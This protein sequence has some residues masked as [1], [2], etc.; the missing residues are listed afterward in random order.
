MNEL[1]DLMLRRPPL[2]LAVAE[3]LTCGRVQARIGTISGASD[4]FLGGMTAYSLEEKAR[5]LGVDRATA[6]AVNCVSGDVAVQMARGACLLFGADVSV[7][8]TGYAEPSEAW[9]VPEPF[10]WWAV[11]RRLP[12]GGFASRFGRQ[13]FPG[14]GRTEAQERA[15]DAAISALVDWVREIRAAG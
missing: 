13:D 4:F 8:T 9:N 10:A 1:R 6:A 2:A 3:S 15:S 11:A 5:H 12:G 14:A 7:A